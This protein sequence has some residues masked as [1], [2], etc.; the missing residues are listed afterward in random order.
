MNI[1]VGTI[2]DV[3]NVLDDRGRAHL[4]DN[5]VEH[6][7]QCTDKDIIRRSVAIFANVDDDFG[8][9]LAEKLHIDVPKKM[10]TAPTVRSKY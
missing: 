6:L 4:I 1:L 5:I 9:R 3:V 10:S 2:C 8:R 7:Q